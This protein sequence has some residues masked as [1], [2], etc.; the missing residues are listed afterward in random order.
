MASPHPHDPDDRPFP[1]AWE[2]DDT[3]GLSVHP[4]TAADA[5]A[6]LAHLPG[7]PDPDRPLRRTPSPARS[8]RPTPARRRRQ[9][10]GTPGA[11]AQ[12]EYQRRRAR[13]HTTWAATLPWRLAATLG[14]G[15]TGWLAATLLSVPLPARAVA[16]VAALAAVGWRLRF[17]PTPETRAWQRGAQGER[18][19]ARL[20]APLEAHGWTVLH[21]LQVPRSAAN[22][23]RW[24]ISDQD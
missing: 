3:P 16:A 4:L 17:R 5:E 12:A 22:T 1:L 8:R 2:D 9:A 6:I 19:L 14:A 24:R 23:G 15:L 20:L 11:S 21:D 18:H 7:E 13:E 10:L